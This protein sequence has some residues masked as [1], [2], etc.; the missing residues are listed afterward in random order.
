MSI[1]KYLAEDRVQSLEDATLRATQAGALNDPFELKP[2]FRTIFT[3][4]YMQHTLDEKAS[5][6][7]VIDSVYRKLSES[8]SPNISKES[9]KQLIQ[10]GDIKRSLN[11]T[12]QAFRAQV[13]DLLPD[14]SK[15]VRDTLFNTLENRIGIVSFT[16]DS[17]NPLMWAHYASQHR[18]FVI[19]FD[20]A[21]AFFDQR[22]SAED[23]FFHLRSV[24]YIP[25]TQIYES[26]LD[27]D[28]TRVLCSKQDCWQYEREVRLLIP[29]TP[30][31]Q[32]SVG[33][34]IH[35]IQFPR[36]CVRRVILGH[37]TS[38]NVEKRIRQVLSRE[39]GYGNVSLCRASAD[40]SYGTMTIKSL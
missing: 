17:T 35:L 29:V 22:R 26:M 28:G 11:E 27:L 20:E 33:E 30:K 8:I 21:H 34:Q 3:P 7:K 37:R 24:T 12:R 6:E 10:R 25:P 16:K 38:E 31:D 15:Q 9:L 36:E 5:D 4:E 40:F 18:G 19:E 39:P 23:E 32:I 2:F 1:Y 14:L 13:N